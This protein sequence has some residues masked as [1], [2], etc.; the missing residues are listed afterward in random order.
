MNAE[1]SQIM[2]FEMRPKWSPGGPPPGAK[3]GDGP[4]QS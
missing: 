2:L 3:P 4:K 1:A